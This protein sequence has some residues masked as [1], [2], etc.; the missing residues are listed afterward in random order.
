MCINTCNRR[1]SAAA[2]RCAS[3]AASRLAAAAASFF[4]LSFSF[5]FSFPFAFLLLPAPLGLVITTGAAAATVPASLL[6]L[7]LLSTEESG[8]LSLLIACLP[9]VLTLGVFALPFELVGEVYDDD[10]KSDAITSLPLLL[11][12]LKLLLLLLLLLLE[13]ASLFWPFL[14]LRGLFLPL[15]VGVLNLLS[16][17]AWSSSS[18]S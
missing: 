2:A 17:A 18:K 13:F 11:L 5:S 1:P 16:L 6:L 15:A 8:A 9:G 12:L 4:R 7:P 3:S 14:L 10:E